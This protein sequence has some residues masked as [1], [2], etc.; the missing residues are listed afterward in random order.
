RR[1]LEIAR[2]LMPRPKVRLLD[3]PTQGLD[4]P[5][6]MRMWDYIR[7]VNAAGTTIC[8]RTP[9]LE[10]A[11]MLSDRISILDHGRIIV[12]GTPEELKNTLGEDVV[13]LETEDDPKARETLK[14][15]EEIRSITESPRGLSITI[16]TDGSHCLPR[17]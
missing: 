11:D 8:V 12:S 5:T 14:G 15:V 6:R 16:S 13:Y 2:G 7:E 3:E 1:R 17:I 9:Y 10:E 4:P